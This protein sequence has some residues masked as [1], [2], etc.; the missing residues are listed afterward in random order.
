[1]LFVFVGY[2]GMTSFKPATKSSSLF[3]GEYDAQYVMQLAAPGLEKS[4]FS[5]N[6]ENDYL[7]ISAEKKTEKEALA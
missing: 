6:I 2:F 4:D 7:V 5:L 3:V 1:M